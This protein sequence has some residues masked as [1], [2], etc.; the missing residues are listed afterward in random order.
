MLT[1][2]KVSFLVPN[3]R[4]GWKLKGLTPKLIVF[5]ECGHGVHSDDL[6]GYYQAVN[7]FLMEQK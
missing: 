6:N 7:D 1:A 5:E 3:K 2:G 4:D